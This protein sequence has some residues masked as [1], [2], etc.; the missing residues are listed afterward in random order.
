[1]SYAAAKVINDSLHMY[2]KSL[3]ISFFTNALDERNYDESAMESTKV[4]HGEDAKDISLGMSMH[5]QEEEEMEEEN[6]EDMNPP[7]LGDV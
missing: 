4:L 7:K 5:H 6:E 1:M 2:M 3:N